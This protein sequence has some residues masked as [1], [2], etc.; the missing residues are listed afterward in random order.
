MAYF[1][2]EYFGRKS[3]Y[4]RETRVYENLIPIRKYTLGLTVRRWG[5]FSFVRLE[6]FR[7][8]RFA[9]TTTT[10]VSGHP[11]NNLSCLRNGSVTAFRTGLYRGS[12]PTL[13]RRR[14]CSLS[15]ETLRNSFSCVSMRTRLPGHDHG[16]RGHRNGVSTVRRSALVL[17][18][19]YR[20]V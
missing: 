2:H 19:L 4:G 16:L 1:R 11:S 7:R 6:E 17:R 5:P 20:V 10:S 9:E 15:S 14:R 8:W 18:S 12:T 13:L 3:V